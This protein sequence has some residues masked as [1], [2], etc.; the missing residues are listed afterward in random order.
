MAFT[1]RWSLQE[2]SSRNQK[3]L[4]KFWTLK[5]KKKQTQKKK[6]KPNK[7][8]TTKPPT[9]SDKTICAGFHAV[10]GNVLQGTVEKR[11]RSK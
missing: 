1:I 7:P 10:E 11:V 4:S 9:S 5:E 6:P 2:F 3:D 8:I